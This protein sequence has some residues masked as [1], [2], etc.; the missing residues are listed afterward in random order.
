MSF[1]ILPHT[2]DVRLKII[3]PSIEALFCDALRGMNEVIKPGFCERKIMAEI[4]ERIVI[5]AQ[6]VSA[7][8]VDFLSE[9]LTQTHIQ[10]AVFC[11]A[12]FL[13]LDEVSLEA[14]IY[15]IQS[16][17]IEKDIKAV[18]YHECEIKKNDDGLYETVIVFDV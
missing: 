9:I 4:K 8:L 3:A 12:E 18:S 17:Q 7:L 11:K 2:A 5:E 16:S 10:H 6:D 15:G 13:K 14:N 1:E